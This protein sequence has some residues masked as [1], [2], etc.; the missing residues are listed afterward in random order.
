MPEFTDR[1]R[2]ILE[3]THDTIIKLKTVILGTNGDMGLAGLVQSNC[4][5]IEKNTRWIWFI[6]G[7]LGLA[8]LG[9][10]LFELLR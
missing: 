8:G 3:D 6:I 5:K 4:A 1:D 2:I 7:A 10:G 9:G